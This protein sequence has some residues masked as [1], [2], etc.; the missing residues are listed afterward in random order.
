ML[1][2]AALGFSVWTLPLASY[3]PRPPP[4]IAD[5]S[6]A[7]VE[8]NSDLPRA[9]RLQLEWS[10]S[11]VL[12][13]GGE[14][15]GLVTDVYWE[16]GRTIACGDP[17]LEVSGNVVVAYCGP[18]PLWREVAGTTLGADRDEVVTFLRDLGRFADIRGNPTSAQFTELVR[19]WQDDLGTEVTGVV[20]PQDLLWIEAPITPSTAT[21][22]VGDRLPADGAVFE[23]APRVTSAVLADFEASPSAL[24]RVFD[25]DGDDQRF[26][27]R[28]GGVV[29]DLTELTA[30]IV[31]LG[32]T[33]GGPPTHASGTTRLRTP[34]DFLTVPATSLVADSTATCVITVSGTDGRRIPVVVEPVM[35]LVGVVFVSGELE[36]GTRV[37]VNPDRARGC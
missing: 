8:R 17:V 14:G 4:T 7:V 3:E 2:S 35:S 21:V 28:S 25:L 10:R 31:E 20:R 16:P 23:V 12:R 19:S 32:L 30:S 34:A 13:A 1:S 15:E 11:R 37:L 18:R 36:A 6:V 27:L 5:E 29:E 24:A 9:A 26:E 33:A 22:S